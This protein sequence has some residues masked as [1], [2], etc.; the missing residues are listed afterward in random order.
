MDLLKLLEALNAFHT[1][2][3][4]SPEETLE[5]LERLVEEAESMIEGLRMTL[6][7]GEE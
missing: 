1:D 2:T 3:T 7:M 4:R 6:A 5:G